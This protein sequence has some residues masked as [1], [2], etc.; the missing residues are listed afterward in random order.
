[1][2]PQEFEIHLENA[3]I[4]EIMEFARA[5]ATHIVAKGRLSG[6]LEPEETAGLDYHVVSGDV[7]REKLAWLWNRYSTEWMD[8]VSNAVGVK[9][10]PCSLDTISVNINAL[11]GAGS[12]YEWHVDSDAYSGVLFL[13]DH[14]EEDGGEFVIEVD[15]RRNII[16]PRRGKLILFDGTICPH[17]VYPLKTNKHRVTVVM[18]FIDPNRAQ[19]TGENEK[20]YSVELYGH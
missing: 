19:L 3:E 5:H 15:G 7:V 18:V 1:M 14:N 12:R 11:Y 4:Q 8:L 17:G 16:H 20:R 10:V 6:S 13:T 2:K 9:C